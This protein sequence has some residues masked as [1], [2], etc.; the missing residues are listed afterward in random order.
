M[1]CRYAVSLQINTFHP[2]GKVGIVGVSISS[3]SGTRPTQLTF[4]W[5]TWTWWRARMKKMRLKRRSVFSTPCRSDTRLSTMTTSFFSVTSTRTHWETWKPRW[6]WYRC[7]KWP[8]L[9]RA[10]TLRMSWESTTYVMLWEVFRATCWPSHLTYRPTY[11]PRMSS[12]SSRSRMPP[13]PC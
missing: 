5:G 1:A 10:R 7:S 13:E 2:L 4:Q 8:D 6:R 11:P 9:Q 12:S 3:T